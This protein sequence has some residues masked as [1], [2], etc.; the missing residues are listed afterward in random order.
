MCAEVTQLQGVQGTNRTSRAT[1][2]CVLRSH[3]VVVR[4]AALSEAATDT[5]NLVAHMVCSYSRMS[6][7]AGN[8]LP[9]TADRARSVQRDGLSGVQ[10]LVPS[11]QCP[12]R[13]RGQPISCPV[14]TGGVWSVKLITHLYLVPS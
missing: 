1:A 9:G 11:S 7:S 14:G 8:V 6:G 4:C 12:Y 13:L 5:L 2:E 3:T 10:W